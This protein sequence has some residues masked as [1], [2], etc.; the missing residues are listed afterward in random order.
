MSL[1]PRPILPVPEET[2]L[3][4]RKAFP[5][6]NLFM[7]MRDDLGPIFEDKQFVSLFPRDGQ[8]A[9]APSRLALVTIM[10]FVENLTDRQAAHAVRARIDWKYALGLELTD[11]GFDGSVLC[12]FRQRLLEGGAE[13]LLFD[14][15]LDRFKA[16]G[17]VRAGGKQRSD[18]TH[19]LAAVRSLNRLELVGETLRAALNSLAE[20]V[21]DWLT[22][23]VPSA[24]FDRY[25]LPFEV[26]R[27]PKKETEQQALAETI[28]RDGFALLGAL[29]QENA[30]SWLRE[31][32][33]VNILRLVWIQQ[34]YGAD[35]GGKW[36]EKEDLPPCSQLIETPYDT[37]VHYASKG[38]THWKGYRIHLTESC[39][40]H[41]PHLITDV[42]TTLATTNDQEMTQ[43][44]QDALAQ[45]DLLPAEHL[46]DAGYTSADIL[47]KSRE[48]G[49]DV[50]GK[51][52]LDPSWQRREETGYDAS[53][54]VIDWEAQQVTCP[55]DKVNY[56]WRPDQTKYGT[57]LI[58]VEFSKSDCSPC[59]ARPLCTR[60]QGQ[61]RVL[62]LAAQPQY[63]AMQA[64][65]QRQTTAEFRKQYAK[66]A[67]VE[68]SISQGTGAFGL[69]CA[70]YRG[71]A[72]TR[73]QHIATVAAINLVRFSDWM[74]D[75]PRSKTRIS[76][77][78]RLKP[79]AA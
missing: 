54:F 23:R 61:K 53:A 58:R 8:P 71:L 21:P 45:H 68:G 74:M 56:R 11:A 6:G 30:P 59:S 40:P 2:A 44:I 29:H 18:S 64:A 36:R 63:E 49:V 31:I 16:K 52:T 69:R 72:K 50:V 79:E 1:K 70:R 38:G 13:R 76:H 10:Q 27:L 14:H 65:R 66:R 55:Q 46:V 78:A 75:R 7:K 12:E 19:V 3:I 57:P 35:A 5:K 39:D 25:A 33:A 43:I 51:V 73:L 20:V 22:A 28:G 9:E 67:G 24:W 4:A 26:G 37:E 17:L 60:A 15:L 32:P 62:A 41:L 34:Y 48:R 47:V 77:F 42:Q